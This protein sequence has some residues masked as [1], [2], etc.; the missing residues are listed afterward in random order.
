RQTLLG[1]NVNDIKAHNMRAVLLALLRYEPVSRVRLAELTG[2]SST[3][4]T[5]L[6]SELLE[7]GTVAEEEIEKLKRRRKVGRPPSALRLVPEARYAVG[8]HIGVGSVGVGIA[9]LR[10][11]LLSYLRL[12]HPLEKSSEDVLTETAALVNEAIRDSGVNPQHVVGIGVGASGLV[13]PQT[14]VN[15]FA[16]N[17]GWRDVPIR[18]WL[19][20]RLGRPVC[21]DNNVRAMALGEALFGAGKDVRALAFV[22]ARIGVGAGFAVDGEL[23]YGGSAGAG[24]IGHTT[25]LPHGGE[26]CR[27]G[28][29][30]CLETLVSEPA[31][32]RLAAE[33]A[34]RNPQGILATGLQCEQGRPIEQILNAARGGD[35]STRDMLNERARYMGIAL[36]NLVNTFNPELILLGGVL[37]QGQDLL[38]PVMEATMR[39][40]AFAN[41]GQQVRLQTTSFGRQAGTVGAATLA[42]NTFF[43]QQPVAV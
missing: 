31:M 42:L 23:Y 38:L 35:S 1:S 19:K 14:G 6:I 7:H 28:N 36:A 13:N 18:D 33:L 5:N 34:K 12:A 11:R 41:L 16:P 15:V 24:E 21:V 22:Y 43:Y 20:E 9:D 17:L 30:G 26:S 10:A 4:I 25:I 2:L 32:V 39:E 27:C 29:T 37:A 40:R 8:I 3:T